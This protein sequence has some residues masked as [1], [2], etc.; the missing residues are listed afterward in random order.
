[1]GYYTRI[2]ESDIFISKDDFEYCYE[3]MCKLNDRD[4]LKSGG[5]W[6]AGISADQPRPEGLSYHPGKWFSWMDADYPDKCKTMEDVLYNLGF[7]NIKYDENG[8]LIDIW[9]DNKTGAEDVFLQAIAPYVKAGSYLNWQG[10]D[11]TN[12]QYFFNGKEIVE[13]AGVITWE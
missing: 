6:G 9:Y 2:T 8:N 4:D 5:S 1:M 7:E 11:G 12:Y 10:E 13:K 3:A